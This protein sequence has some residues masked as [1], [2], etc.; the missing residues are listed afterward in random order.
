MKNIP[1]TIECVGAETIESFFLNFHKVFSDSN[2]SDKLL[3]YMV[4][5]YSN[6]NSQQ[7]VDMLLIKQFV[8][9]NMQEHIMYL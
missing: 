7:S 6:M 1:Q 9:E 4:M 3:D 8:R 2:V 5:N